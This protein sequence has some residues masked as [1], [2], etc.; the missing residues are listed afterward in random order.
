MKLYTRVAYVMC[1]AFLVN[2]V[3]GSHLSNP[4]QTSGNDRR[5]A[6]MGDS[7][8]DF[9]RDVQKEILF[10]IDLTSKP[11]LKDKTNEAQRK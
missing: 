11:S 8:K 6:E 1:A 9:M 5:I 4:N 10:Q 3:H 2:Q 7:L